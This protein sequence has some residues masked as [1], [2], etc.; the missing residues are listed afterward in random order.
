MSYATLADLRDFL[1]KYDITETSK[2]TSTQA[3]GYLSRVSSL[4]DG[5]LAGQ[6]YSVPITGAESVE[7]LRHINLLGAGY[8]TTRIMFP[9]NTNG[10]VTELRDE[11]VLMMNL[12]RNEEMQLPDATTAP[13]NVAIDA[14]SLGFPEDSCWYETNPFITRVEQ[15]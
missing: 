3:A 2:P 7:I 5:I 13:E 9:S 10:M 12:L 6:G 8:W 4:L 14:S 1:P 11:Y 15:F